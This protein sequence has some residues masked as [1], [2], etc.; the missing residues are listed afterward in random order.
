M[1]FK[2]ATSANWKAVLL[3]IQRA[4]DRKQFRTADGLTFKDMVESH[5]R[6]YRDEGG[7]AEVIEYLH[8]Q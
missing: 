2:T 5:S 3:L 7:L 8:R 1:V 6:M 4:A